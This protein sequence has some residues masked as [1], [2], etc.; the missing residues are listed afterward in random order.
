LASQ[1]PS[2]KTQN[3]DI[4]PG[5]FLSIPTAALR[6]SHGDGKLDRLDPRRGLRVE[7]V[8][9]PSGANSYALTVPA[10]PGIRYQVQAKN[11]LSDTQWTNVGEAVEAVLGTVTLSGNNTSQTG[12]AVFY[13]VQAM[14]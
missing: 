4:E 5:E 8:E 11:S 7:G 9:R 10:V 6:D 14:Q 12:P 13:R 2:A 1:A 3:G